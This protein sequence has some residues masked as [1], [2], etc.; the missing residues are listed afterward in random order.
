M[1][2]RD[3][4]HFKVYREQTRVKHQI[5]E[6]YLPA[7][8][9]ILKRHHKNLLYV[10]AFAGRGTYTDESTGETVD[11]SPLRA[12]KLIASRDD[13]AARV[14]TVFV[15]SDPVNFASLEGAVTAFCAANEQIREPEVLRGTFA[16]TVG[17]IIEEFSDREHQLAPTFLLVD[18]CG[19]EG[20]SFQVIKGIMR[21][22]SCEAFIFFNYQGVRRTAGLESMSPVLVDLYGSTARAERLLEALRQGR[23]SYEREQTIVT[24]YK[25]AVAE[26]IGAPYIIAFRVE[27]ERRREG[28]HY[29]LHVTKHPLGFK[30]MKD[31]MWRRGR[32]AEGVGGLELVQASRSGRALIRPNWEAMKQRITDALARGPVKVDVFYSDWVERPDDVFS[33]PAYKQALLELESE[34][35]IDVLDKQCK[36]RYAMKPEGPRLPGTLGKD[37]YVQLRR[38][39]DQG[40]GARGTD[41]EM[42]T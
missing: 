22:D 27:C 24:H 25:E 2:R 18:P 12:L 26:E 29:L 7:F 14:T 35:K 1:S 42:S 30:I 38:G 23:N 32:T 28:S 41:T 16:E 9:H 6:G 10:D 36:K 19:V 37:Y 31:V 8:F 40:T 39:R 15:E 3:R 21:F 34:R 4:E 33:E 11:G 5:L 13:F 20:T 17:E